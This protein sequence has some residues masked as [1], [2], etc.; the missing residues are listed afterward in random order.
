MTDLQAKA[1]VL[2]QSDKLFFK[3]WFEYCQSSEKEV[4]MQKFCARMIQEKA[5]THVDW[6]LEEMHKTG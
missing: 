3:E 2:E 6:M 4:Q 5:R 1:T